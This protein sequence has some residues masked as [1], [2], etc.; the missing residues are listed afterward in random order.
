MSSE[1]FGIT[2]ARKGGNCNNCQEPYS[3]GETIA[4]DNDRPKRQG[5]VCLECA[6]QEGGGGL[7]RGRVKNATARLTAASNELSEEQFDTIMRKFEQLEFVKD[8]VNE[9]QIVVNNMAEV[10]FA[11]QRQE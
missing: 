4:W 9:I 6:Q 8:R 7:P 2:T 5:Q 10:I 11:L 1:R 3:A